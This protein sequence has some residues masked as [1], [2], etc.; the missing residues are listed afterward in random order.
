MHLTQFFVFRCDK[1]YVG[2]RLPSKNAEVAGR[3]RSRSSL[4]CKIRILE[5]EIRGE[6]L[7]KTRTC[8]AST[9][10]LLTQMTYG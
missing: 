10:T 8:K 6:V 2:L 3:W 4:T 1:C 7:I 5:G 9:A